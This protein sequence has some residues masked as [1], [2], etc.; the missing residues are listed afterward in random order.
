MDRKNGHH[1][2]HPPSQAHYGISHSHSVEM[3][4]TDWPLMWCTWRLSFQ[5]N[6]IR[7][8]WTYLPLLVATKTDHIDNDAVR[9]FLCP[10][11]NSL[12]W[13]GIVFASKQPK[14]VDPM[15]PG[16][17]IWW[18]AMC[19]KWKFQLGNLTR[20]LFDFICQTF[21]AVLCVLSVPLFFGLASAL[22]YKIPFLLLPVDATMECRR[23]TQCDRMN[24][25]QPQFTCGSCGVVAHKM[26]Q[27]H[28][29]TPLAN[30]FLF[31]Y[32]LAP[33]TMW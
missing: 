5:I 33:S 32:I 18:F 17:I 9:P 24:I 28:S 2:H 26:Q 23:R 12:S 14:A 15:A 7:L 6:L 31:L 25:Y 1:V 30:L 16:I 21:V 29:S 8:S 10:T 22:N 19:T 20:S 13:I 4:A 3:Q 11:R 27:W